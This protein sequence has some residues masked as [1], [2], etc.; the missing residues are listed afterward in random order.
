MDL[1]KPFKPTKV[2]L[3]EAKEAYP[4]WYQRVVVEKQKK[5]KKWEISKKVNGDDPY[6]LYHWWIRQSDK[7]AGG[8]RYYF[9]MC[10]A[11]YA[12]KCD[13]PKRQ[14]V[15]DM[16]A[17]FD[18]IAGIE[19][20]NPLTKDDM[21]SALE[22]YDK[23]Y[24]DTSI[25]EIEYWTDVRIDRNK[26]NGRKQKQHC[27]VMRVIQNVV[28]PK[29]RDGNGRPSAEQKVREWRETHPEGKKADCI[30]ETGLSKPTVYK[31][32]I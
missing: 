30:R 18:R 16:N 7:I 27:E 31:W 4:D 20:V 12:C 11:I 21:K 26:R 3:L 32:W 2:T 9:L 24:Y 15:Q 29:W 8:H 22:A 17:I 14:L 6:A 10:M 1:N 23:E 5:P 28:N 19:H 25:S 13:V